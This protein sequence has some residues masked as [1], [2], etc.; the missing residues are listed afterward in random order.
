MIENLTAWIAYKLPKRLAYWAAIR[1][2]SYATVGQYSST[3][4][5]ELKAIDA[6]QR[7]K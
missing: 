6:L 4:V 5:P 2:M 7:W 3:I 1:I